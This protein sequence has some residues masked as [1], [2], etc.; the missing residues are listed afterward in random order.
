MD[1]NHF[2]NSPNAPVTTT[3]VAETTTATIKTATTTN[4]T[5]GITLKI[6]TTS[7]TAT[8]T[9]NFSVSSIVEQ[10]T[11]TPIVTQNLGFIKFVIFLALHI[12]KPMKHYNNESSNLQYGAIISEETCKQ[13]I[14]NI[15][16]FTR[17]IKPLILVPLRTLP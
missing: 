16:L 9:T 11:S 1:Y 13:K 5:T 14:S 2:Y 17:Q 10:S 7:Q 8:P 4:S 15:P 3:T 6:A 12:P